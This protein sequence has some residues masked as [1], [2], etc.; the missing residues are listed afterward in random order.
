MYQNEQFIGL[1][2]EQVTL[3]RSRHGQNSTVIS[4]KRDFFVILKEIVLE[5]LFILLVVSAFVYFLSGSKREGFIMIAS[6]TFV[7]GISFFQENKSRKAINALKRLNA[8]VAKV[9]R[10]SIT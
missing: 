3:S 9:I 4:G 2:E 7:A 6:L 1:T 5:P 10:N 8:P